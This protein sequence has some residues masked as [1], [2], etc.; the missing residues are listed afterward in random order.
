MITQQTATRLN[1]HLNQEFFSAFF[2]LSLSAQAQTLGLRG[3]AAWFMAKHDEELA[4]AM[5]LYKY[6]LDQG[7]EIKLQALD[8]PPT[9]SAGV[10]DMFEMTLAH[11]QSVTRAINDLVDAALT[12]KDHATSIFLQWYVTE[13]IEEESV[14]GDVIARMRLVGT[15]GEGLFMIDNEMAQLAA[16]LATPSTVGA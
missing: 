6:I 12:E 5:K 16:Q 13:Q 14:V 15:Q 10:L 9:N 2:Y 3:V 1:A 4:H 7:A 8:C 11:E